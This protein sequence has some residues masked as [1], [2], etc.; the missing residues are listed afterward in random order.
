MVTEEKKVEVGEKK[1][2]KGRLREK[3]R[4]KIR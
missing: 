2:N 3:K 1:R 4:G